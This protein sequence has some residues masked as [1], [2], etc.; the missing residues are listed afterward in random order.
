MVSTF[1]VL[2][3]FRQVCDEEAVLLYYNSPHITLFED[4]AVVAEFFLQRAVE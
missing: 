3:C 1:S 4:L 2:N